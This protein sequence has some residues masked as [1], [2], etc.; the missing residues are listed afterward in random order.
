MH[1][2]IVLHTCLILYS[3][4]G[5]EAI[6]FIPTIAPRSLRQHSINQPQ[7]I[8]YSS[9][10]F[11]ESFRVPEKWVACNGLQWATVQTVRRT[12]IT[13]RDDLLWQALSQIFNRV[14]SGFNANANKS[15]K[16]IQEYY[17][18]VFCRFTNIW[19]ERLA[20]CALRR[21]ALVTRVTQSI[22]E[23]GKREGKHTFNES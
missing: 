3:G 17:S 4:L 21:R 6:C 16:Y 13:S 20:A 22:T 1:Q 10:L 9:R 11:I 19:Q 2:F 23:S 15:A 12:T 7:H 5:I 8:L 14:R 18:N